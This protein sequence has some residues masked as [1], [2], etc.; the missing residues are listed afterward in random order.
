MGSVLVG[1]SGGLF[2][3]KANIAKI[4]VF[5]FWPVDWN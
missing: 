4:A 5:E 2:F 3:L 1:L